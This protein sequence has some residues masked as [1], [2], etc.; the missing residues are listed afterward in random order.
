MHYGLVLTACVLVGVASS[1]CLAQGNPARRTTVTDWP[2]IV[3]DPY[4]DVPTDGAKLTARRSW[5]A[6]LECPRTAPR[7]PGGPSGRPD[8][9]A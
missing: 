7:T 6:D 5:L 8:Q 1:T 2:R 3:Q 4:A 9:P